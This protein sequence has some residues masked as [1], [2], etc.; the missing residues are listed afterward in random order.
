[1]EDS[2]GSARFL[3]SASDG[4]GGFT[5][6]GECM[7]E[8]TCCLS[9]RVA[10]GVRLCSRWG[11]ESG[12]EMPVRTGAGGENGG[13]SSAKAERP[14]LETLCSMQTKPFVRVPR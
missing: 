11:G 13:D 8:P 10:E 7:G 5:L 1:M 12:G 9:I 3:V 6:F 4:G 14:S 2:G